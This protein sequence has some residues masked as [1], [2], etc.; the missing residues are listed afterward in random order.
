MIE[1]LRNNY[2]KKAAGNQVKGYQYE[3]RS[4]LEYEQLKEV[5]ETVLDEILTNLKKARTKSKEM[6]VRSSK[7]VQTQNEPPKQQKVRELA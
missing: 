3:I 6:V 5:I 7:A 1:L 2:I 4:Y